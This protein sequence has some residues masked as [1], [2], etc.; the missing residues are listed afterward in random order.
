MLWANSPSS[1]FRVQRWAGRC[2]LGPPGTHAPQALLPVSELTLT[3]LCSWSSQLYRQ[4]STKH[5]SLCQEGC[6]A[7]SWGE[8]LIWAGIGRSSSVGDA[9]GGCFASSDPVMLRCHGPASPEGLET[10]APALPAPPMLVR[11]SQCDG[12]CFESSFIAGRA[13][14][15]N[16]KSSN[17][18]LP[19]CCWP[20]R[21]NN[22]GRGGRFLPRESWRNPGGPRRPH[23]P[24]LWCFPLPAGISWPER[25]KKCR[26]LSLP[27]DTPWF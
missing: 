26:C 13:S 2:L 12:R 17:L 23:P 5:P 16:T 6:A 22:L 25:R 20:H 15:P 7:T 10:A 9:V 24:L 21:V 1:A 18:L 4:Q 11:E 27:A 3:S 14:L 8:T 19:V